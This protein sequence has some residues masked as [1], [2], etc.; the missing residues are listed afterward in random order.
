MK[1]EDAET[2]HD[3]FVSEVKSKGTVWASP[4]HAQSYPCTIDRHAILPWQWDGELFAMTLTG[5][6][7]VCNDKMPAFHVYHLTEQEQAKYG[8]ELS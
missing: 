5:K 3:S 8:A 6:R 7:A 2:R 4:S 1:R